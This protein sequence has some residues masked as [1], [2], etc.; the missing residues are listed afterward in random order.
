MNIALWNTLLKTSLLYNSEVDHIEKCVRSGESSNLTMKALVQL[1]GVFL[2]LSYHRMETLAALQQRSP[3]SKEYFATNDLD[4]AWKQ[5]HSTYTCSKEELNDGL[6]I[7]EFVMNM[8]D[9]PMNDRE[10][11]SFIKAFERLIA[12]T[13]DIASSETF[14]EVSSG[15][16]DVNEV[17][18]G[19]KT[20]HVNG[21]ENSSNEESANV[22]ENSEHIHTSTHLEEVRTENQQ[23][24]NEDRAESTTFDSCA[25]F[26]QLSVLQTSSVE[27][28]VHA[29]EFTSLQQYMHV[30]RPI[31]NHFLQ[32]LE[33][34][35]TTDAPSLIMLCGSVGDGKSHLI[36]YIQEM[37]PDLLKGFYVHNDSTESHNPSEDEIETLERVLAGF[38]QNRRGSN[39]IVLAINLG[40][41]HNFYVKHRSTSHFST[42]VKAIEASSIFEMDQ[43]ISQSI[44]DITFLNFAGLQP[45]D[46]DETGA[47]SPFFK[48]IIEK[49]TAPV[50]EN[51]FYQSWK[52]DKERGIWTPVHLN[53]SLL[54]D[55]K[56]RDAV[57]RVLVEAMIKE[58]LFLSTRALYNVI[59]DML[60]PLDIEAFDPDHL[61][62][63]LLFS[64]PERS[65]LMRALHTIDPVARRNE[66]FDE[67]L[68]QFIIIDDKSSLIKQHIIEDEA[69]VQMWEAIDGEIES[70]S[71]LLIRHYYLLHH[72][73]LNESYHQ[74]LRTL[75]SYYTGST[76]AYEELYQVISEAIKRWIGSPKEHYIYIDAKSESDY[77]LAI[78]FQFDHAIPGRKY[79]QA[80]G[81]A[82][83]SRL[84]PE[85]ELGL[86]VEGEVLYVM[87]DYD[88]FD[89]LVRVAKGY[90]P[91][92][93]DYAEALQFVEFYNAIVQHTDKAKELLIVH[94]STLH[95]IQMKKPLFRMGATKYEVR[96]LE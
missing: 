50:E 54:Q 66:V 17:E 7:N 6:A 55:E 22:T 62:P 59:Y 11:H 36:S 23:S 16:D 31:Q 48:A 52:A 75:Y 56:M 1:Q 73:T 93:R 78:P 90:R 25:F 44:E 37:R 68:R 40:V 95:M 35:Q 91:T 92:R 74:F 15:A 39:R 72:R 32:S 45:Y 18:R 70:Y 26:D 24:D 83:V 43:D 3:L 80:R 28:V 57:V 64:R 13:F 60:V 42:I 4:Y 85:V 21:V 65:D 81:A 89:L 20:D 67:L 51:P 34:A 49:V 77:R 69:Y 96:S 19:S 33:G 88:L 10:K 5:I 46:L 38:E 94:S 63:S 71:K 14:Y 41:L 82:K 87:I 61:L 27:S 12:R 47:T 29:D 9:R 79:R 58:K 86:Q 2:Q 53:Y 30:E 8:W 84:K 76:E